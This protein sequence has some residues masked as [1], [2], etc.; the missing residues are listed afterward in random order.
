MDYEGL[1]ETLTN[2]CWELQ[3]HNSVVYIIYAD[4]RLRAISQNTQ[5]KESTE[6]AV[7]E[8][9][10]NHTLEELKYLAVY[11]QRINLSSCVYSCDRFNVVVVS[12][13][14]SGNDYRLVSLFSSILR[15]TCLMYEIGGE[16]VQDN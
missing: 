11:C 6:G 9:V 1:Y 3:P 14:P 10:K 16:H 2:I 4:G 5:L 7:S 13:K 8:A 15:K 12:G